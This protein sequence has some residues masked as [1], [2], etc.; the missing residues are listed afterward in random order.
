MYF[1]QKRITGADPN[2]ISAEED[3]QMESAQLDR[4]EEDVTGTERFLQADLPV[5]AVTA[6]LLS[7]NG[8]QIGNPLQR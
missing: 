8:H 3:G 7:P 5:F 4:V 1:I 2:E 6:A